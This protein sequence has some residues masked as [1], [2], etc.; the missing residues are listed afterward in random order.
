MNRQ[1]LNRNIQTCT[2]CKLSGT[3]TNALPGEGPCP[4]RL[5]MVAQ[6]PGKTE[7]IENRMFVGPSGK[8]FDIL[9]NKAGLTRDDFYLTN[10]IKCML[11]KS[12]RP[13]H[14]E[15]A[16]CTPYLDIEIKLVKPKVIVPLGFHSTRYILRKFGLDIPPKKEFHRLFGHLIRIDPYLIFPV[17]HPTAL[18]FDKEKESVM[19]QNYKKIKKL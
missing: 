1:A 12:R 4:A 19:M 2:L 9:I 17:R 18:L 14:D 15:L 10:L 13:S 7:D 3:R 11:P 8:V 5:M 6:S 16:Q